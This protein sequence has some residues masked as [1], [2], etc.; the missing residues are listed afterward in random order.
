MTITAGLV[1]TIFWIYSYG[2][3]RVHG[4]SCIINHFASKHGK[5][6]A[7]LLEQS[8]LPKSSQVAEK[9]Q[10]STISTADEPSGTYFQGVEMA[11]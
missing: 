6:R 5:F 1:S 8:D 11:L 9:C 2:F 4:I 10:G 7:G 3:N